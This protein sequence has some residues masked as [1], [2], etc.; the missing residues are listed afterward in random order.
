MLSLL[1]LPLLLLPLLL[2]PSYICQVRP[3]TVFFLFELCCH[4]CPCA[5]PNHPSLAMPHKC[6]RSPPKLATPRKKTANGWKEDYRH[7]LP[8]NKISAPRISKRLTMP[9]LPTN[10]ISAPNSLQGLA[11]QVPEL[12]AV[13]SGLFGKT[14]RCTGDQ[15]ASIHVSFPGL[16][17]G[18][19]DVSRQVALVVVLPAPL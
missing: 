9:C 13:F 11:A 6:G 8:T 16:L 10:K 18:I 7:R 19:L 14:P 2:W 12:P 5:V 15:P 1:P 4:A 3:R 17:P